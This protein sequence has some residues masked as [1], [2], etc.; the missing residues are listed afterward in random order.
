MFRAAARIQPTSA[1]AYNNLGVIL[2][3]QGRLSEAIFV[4]GRAVKLNPNF[5][6]ARKNLEAVQQKSEAGTSPPTKPSPTS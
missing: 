2:A 3:A 5:T 1:E 4:L 6:A